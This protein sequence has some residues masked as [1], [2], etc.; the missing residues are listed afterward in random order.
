MYPFKSIGSGLWGVWALGS[1]LE[2][3][4]D[5]MQENTRIL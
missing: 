5:V 1:V 4:R 2:G 3:D